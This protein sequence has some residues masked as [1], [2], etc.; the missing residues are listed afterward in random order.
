MYCAET[1]K[2][3]EIYEKVKVM[4]N[5]AN[6]C[7]YWTF[8]SYNQAINRWINYSVNQFKHYPQ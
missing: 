5:L 3:K 1:K 7:N 4:D 6:L 8:V 2:T